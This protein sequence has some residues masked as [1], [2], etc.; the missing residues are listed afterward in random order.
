MEVLASK[1]LTEP[2][3][4]VTCRFLKRELFKTFLAGLSE[5]E[6][7]LI[8][9]PCLGATLSFGVLDPVVGLGS[10]AGGCDT[11]E[12]SSG[13]GFWSTPIDMDLF[14]ID[15]LDRGDVKK[16]FSAPHL[17]DSFSTTF[18]REGA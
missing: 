9:N 6:L 4:I 3:V 13:R 7:R 18:G 16:V 11:D 1:P 17:I 5:V 2:R 12:R 8:E 15:L 14:I 10:A